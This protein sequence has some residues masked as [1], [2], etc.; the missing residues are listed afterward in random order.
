MSDPIAEL[1]ETAGLLLERYDGAIEKV[2][3]V[4]DDAL[5]KVSKVTD[6]IAG[7]VAEKIGASGGGAMGPLNGQMESK[8]IPMNYQ[9]KFRYSDSWCQVGDFVAVFVQSSYSR[10]DSNKYGS[11]SN[12]A[13]ATEIIIINADG[14]I[15]DKKTIQTSGN[16][17][18]NHVTS[19]K[20]MSKGDFVAFHTNLHY[21]K[22]CRRYGGTFRVGDDGKIRSYANGD[23][24]FALKTASN[25]SVRT[26][27]HP[28]WNSSNLRCII[29]D[30]SQEY[31]VV[32]SF[33]FNNNNNDNSRFTMYLEAKGRK[34]NLGNNRDNNCNI[35]EIHENAI[36][37]QLP[38]SIKY[39][40]FDSSGT[41]KVL[42]ES[43]VIK[44]KYFEANNSGLYS[45]IS[46]RYVAAVND[47]Y[48][49]VN[50]SN[51]ASSFKLKA[52]NLLYYNSMSYTHSRIQK[53]KI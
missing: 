21:D 1:S 28:Y 48:V 8:M 6:D 51:M 25:S 4:A 19:P 26:N 43:E 41:F 29:N 23:W 15:T 40:G 11:S 34:V 46:G 30:G 36:L 5:A 14:R 45:Q 16:N 7:E 35:L 42:N 17:G 49:L 18:C 13:G 52:K 2:E 37:V 38:D 3:K 33:S 12:N 9:Y 24:S 10:A 47:K 20:I 31:A 44:S 50:N 53:L 39:V 27:N 32:Y 22:E